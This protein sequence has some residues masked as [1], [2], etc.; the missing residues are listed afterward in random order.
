MRAKYLWALAFCG[1]LFTAGCSTRADRAPSDGAGAAGPGADT[2]AADSTAA[3]AAGAG[4]AELSA[5][6]YLSKVDGLHVT[7][8]AVEVD[9]ETFRLE[10]LGKVDSPLALGLDEI[11]GMEAVRLEA[12]LIC[13]GFFVDKGFWT[14]V[15]VRS[16][17]ESAGV[18]AGAREVAF[19]S[20]D[21]SYTRNLPLDK[22]LETQMLV[23]YEFDD[24][25]LHV[26]HGF[27]L[28]LV[29]P[30]QPGNVWVKWLGRITVQ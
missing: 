10:V 14:G 26:L 3:D 13:P 11:R 30:G 2:V 18:K 7:G 21:G 17:L 9:V 25:E 19:Q 5:S 1:A 24:R 23:G 27:P 20:V 22:A 16:L 4:A 8:T 28:R 15:P 29:A 6:L 12:D